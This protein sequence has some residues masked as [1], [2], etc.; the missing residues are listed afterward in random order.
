VAETIFH[1]DLGQKPL[2]WKW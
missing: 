1:T 2:S